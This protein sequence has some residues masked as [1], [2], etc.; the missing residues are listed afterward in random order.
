M[1]TPLGPL[2]V[3]TDR[4][5]AGDAGHRLI[6]VVRAAADAGADAV[7]YREKDLPAPDRRR[8]GHSI[9]EAL[10]GRQTRLIVASDP[11]LA[12]ELDAGLH[13]S[14]AD[15]AA[16]ERPWPIGRSCH[17]L[18]ELQAA[19]RATADYVTLSPIFPTP[20]KPGYGPALGPDGAAPLI[21]ATTSV[22]Y[23]LGGVTPECVA[24]CMGAG[25]AGVAT[26]GQVMAADEPAHVVAAFR[27][28]LVDEQ[29]AAR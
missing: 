7:I 2:L 26:M 17:D 18:A 15:P 9:R 20:S 25:F 5:A 27:R 14:A 4:R 21:A 19:D 12:D 22:A 6:D 24:A 23:A 13:L 8:L 29:V 11:V 1:T 16:T 28:S 10:N 3:L